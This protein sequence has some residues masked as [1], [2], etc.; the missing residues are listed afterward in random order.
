MVL[1]SLHTSN[2]ADFPTVKFYNFLNEYG[3]GQVPSSAHI[4]GPQQTSPRAYQPAALHSTRWSI[5]HTLLNTRLP[6][7]LHF[8]IQYCFLHLSVSI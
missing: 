3:E 1:S 5:Q 7:C 8:T 4:T 2:V 6:C